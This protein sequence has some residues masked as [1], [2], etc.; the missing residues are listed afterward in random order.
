VG[1][2]WFSLGFFAVHLGAYVVAG[3]LT[4]TWSKDIYHGPEAL[5]A[6]VLRDVSEEDE[7]RRQGR[8]MVPAQLVRAL[9]M[10]VVLYPLIEPLG[11]LDY[12][13]RLAVLGGLMLVYADVASASPFPNT[14]EGLVYLRSR[15]IT[16][17]AFWRLQS[18][19]VIYS[20]LFG[21]V[22][23]WVLF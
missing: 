2:V 12:P 22:A 4:Q 5:L 3:V 11:G 6:P 7:R 23:A 18:E 15:F 14:V 19:A 20:L 9:L 8:L 1:Y 21:A 13:V 10:S 16:P 17:S